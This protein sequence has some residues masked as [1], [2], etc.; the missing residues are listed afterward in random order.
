M[1]EPTPILDALR[2][3]GMS[4]A[5]LDFV[6][7][8]M[9]RLVDEKSVPPPDGERWY[10]D[11]IDELVGELLEK[12]YKALFIAIQT[13]TS[14]RQVK[15]WLRKTATNLLND[16][17]RETLR[18]RLTRRL[19]RIVATVDG[20]THD[21]VHFYG[22]ASGQIDPSDRNAL[23]RQTEKVDTVTDW[24]ADD[25]DDPPSGERSDII[26]LVRC[27]TDA[28]HGPVPIEVAVDVIAQRLSLPLRW[29]EEEIDLEA[30]TAEAA[31]H[32]IPKADAD[33]AVRMISQLTD[34]EQAALPHFA[35]DPDISSDDLGAAIGKGRSTGATVK[36][37]LVARLKQFADDDPAAEAALR[38]IGREVLAGRF[39]LIG[40]S[41]DEDVMEER[42][43]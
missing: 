21:K 28:A 39:E 10:R 35:I 32:D 7:D 43:A 12:K 38:Y 30:T 24:W 5:F 34:N 2:G 18:G 26:A 15:A 8:L 41:I 33:A 37:S 16:R 27:I 25:R 6:V 11:D 29:R 20:L 3:E 4:D 14:D 19:E 31:R 36:R 23:I 40:R 9:R 13:M 17:G 42:R 1:I 22:S